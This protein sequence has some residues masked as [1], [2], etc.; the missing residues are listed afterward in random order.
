M[1][2]YLQLDIKDQQK[3][4]IIM[5]LISICISLVLSFHTVAIA[6]TGK[7]GNLIAV[8]EGGILLIDEHVYLLSSDVVVRSETGDR[9]SLNNVS[10]PA[11]IYF[12]YK[13]T[14]MGP[15]VKLIKVLSKENTQDIIPQ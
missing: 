14:G 11:R 12:E 4:V 2:R 10:M 7:K 5:V 9:I 1:K 6:D 3:K 13:D 15:L 8:E